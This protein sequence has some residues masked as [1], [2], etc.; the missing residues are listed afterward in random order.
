MLAPHKIEELCG[1]QDSLSSL[2]ALLH[3]GENRVI[4]ICASKAM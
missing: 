2:L 3:A 4:P 1:L